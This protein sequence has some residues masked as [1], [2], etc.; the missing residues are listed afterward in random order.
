MKLTSDLPGLVG[1]EVD[2][3]APETGLS[4]L[5]I[6]FTAP[7]NPDIGTITQPVPLPGAGVAVRLAADGLPLNVPGGWKVQIN[8]VTAT[9]VVTAP[10]QT[11]VIRNADGS[12]PEASITIPPVTIAPI[13]DCSTASVTQGI[14]D[15]QGSVATLDIAG[16]NSEKDRATLQGKLSAAVIKIDEGKPLDAAAKLTDFRNRIGQ[17]RDAGKISTSDAAILVATADSIIL[18]LGGPI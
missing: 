18:C 4:G 6:V 3:D 8:A 13:T 2:V 16:Q 5:E 11:F 1:M 7:A 17:L 9:G 14:V 12:T 10:E 15:L